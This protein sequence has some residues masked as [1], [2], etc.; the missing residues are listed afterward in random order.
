MYDLFDDANEDFDSATFGF[1][2]IV[3]LVFQSPHEDRFSAF[4]EN[5]KAS[6]RN[7]HHTVRAIW[8]NTIDYDTPPRFEPPLP[9]RTVLQ[10]FGWEN[11]IDLRAYSADEESN[12]WELDWGVV[13]VSDERCGVTIDVGDYV[14]IH[15]QAGWWGSC[16]VSIRV[17]DSL[18]TAEDTF[19]VDV[20]PVRARVFLPLALKNAPEGKG[21]EDEASMA[22]CDF[23]V[24]SGRVLG[25]GCA[26]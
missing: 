7:K 2:P 16:E 19:R 9:D 5:W 13:H 22:N 10:G 23:D 26:R 15:P 4:W 21:G 6:G 14:D 17:S 1:V 11:A 25:K 12:D 8:Q 18:K 3:T 20:V 24:P